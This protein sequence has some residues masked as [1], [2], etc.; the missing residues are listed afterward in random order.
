[1]YTK[2][3]RCNHARKPCKKKAISYFLQHTHT[4]RF[5]HRLM[6]VWLMVMMMTWHLAGHTHR[7]WTPSDFTG[8]LQRGRFGNEAWHSCC[9]LRNRKF[10]GKRRE[11][12]ERKKALAPQINRA[13]VLTSSITVSQTHDN[14]NWL[15]RKVG[16][17]LDLT[18]GRTMTAAS[19]WLWESDRAFILIELLWILSLSAG[20]FQ[21]ARNPLNKHQNDYT[22]H[23]LTLSFNA[24]K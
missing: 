22:A 18:D 8:S 15:Q 16:I 23:T 10:R 1:M 17:S 24:S 3:L 9:I 4:H 12:E 11:R 13:D 7:W 2:D 5:T 19:L 6:Q 14:Q 20:I 21:I